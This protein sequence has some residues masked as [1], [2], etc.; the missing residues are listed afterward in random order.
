MYA[1]VPIIAPVRVSCTSN[2]PAAAACAGA[3]M[4]AV[5]AGSTTVS[6]TSTFTS[7]TASRSASAAAG[8]R[9]RRRGRSPLAVPGSLAG[10]DGPDL[11][12]LAALSPAAGLLGH[13]AREPEVHDAH[14]AVA[15]DHDVVG[16]EVA[17][18]EPLLVRGREPAPRRHEHLQDLLPAARRGLQPVGDGVPLDELHRD[19]H[20]LLERADVVDDDDV[21]VRQPRDRLRLAQRALPPLVA[22][23]AVAGLHPQQLDR[24]L[25]IQLGIVRRVDL[26]H[27][28]A[29]DQP[30]HD[31]AADGRAPR[32]R[33]QGLVFGE[34]ALSGI[35]GLPDPE[36]HIGRFA[37]DV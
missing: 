33:R 35:V 20:L 28:A 6:G 10:G 1:G 5:G 29:A 37:R 17:V 23:D 12:P 18:H 3:S 16:L 25:A 19:E 15:P 21:R 24:D 14:L 4:D 13:L 9:R 22:G 8:L 34:G 26:A 7:R 36:T 31:V 30:E 32:Q 27:A 2:I 11:S